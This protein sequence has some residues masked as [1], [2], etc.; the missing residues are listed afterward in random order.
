M[1]DGLSCDPWRLS[2]F[3][4]LIVLLIEHGYCPG[5]GLMARILD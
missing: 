2:R 5:A 4:T 1:S 3:A